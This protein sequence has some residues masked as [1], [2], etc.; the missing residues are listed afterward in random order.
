[1]QKVSFAIQNQLVASTCSCFVVLPWPHAPPRR[2]LHS[3]VQCRCLSQ[4][5][6]PCG[7]R[8]YSRIC[9]QSRQPIPTTW[10]HSLTRT[11]DSTASAIHR[12]PSMGS[13]PPIHT[14]ISHRF[15][16]MPVKTR[17]DVSLG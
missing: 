7:C 14:A 2:R 3:I 17:P 4:T 12:R 8:C 10:Q 9:S 16:T 15:K 1:M 6:D 11:A 13:S 5:D